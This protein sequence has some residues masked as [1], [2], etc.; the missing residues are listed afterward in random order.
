M[1]TGGLIEV[2]D[3][4]MENRQN[5]EEIV[6]RAGLPAAMRLI[7]G[8]TPRSPD[9]HDRFEAWWRGAAPNSRR[10]FASDM[11]SWQ[12]HC[13]A[14]GQSPV[15]TGPLELRDYIRALAGRQ[16][17]S[18]TVA[19]HLGNISMLH[20]I[21]GLG[22]A[23]ISDPIV[24]GEMK[25]LRRDQAAA[26][27]GLP[28]QATGLRLKGDVD[29]VVADQPLDLSVLSLLGT[30]DMGKTGH[31]RDALLLRLGADLGRRRSEYAALNVG[32]V[33]MAGDGSGVVIIRRSKTDQSGTGSSKYLSKAT[34]RVIRSWLG[35]RQIQAGAA[36]PPEA[37][38]LTAVDRFGRIGTRL[39]GSAIRELV[40]G[41]AKRGLKL[42]D[43]E[44]SDGD[45]AMRVEGL[46]GHSF[47]VGLAQDLTAAGEGTT[48]IC[49]AADWAS[50]AMPVRYGQA[51]AARSGAVA[52]LQ[53]RF[54]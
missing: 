35:L 22:P 32:D 6:A 44:I 2:L 24:R 19:R 53:R 50:P 9:C 47:R 38:L 52:R 40:I 11:R 1:L 51:L 39:S 48:A 20:Q 7:L 34:M 33:T 54:E 46:S 45:L 10:A 12:T 23:P 25:C 36:L 8:A 18:S 5:L 13:I 4:T 49:Q 27:R 17:R 21:M 30:L 42:L 37:P 31:V 28:R 29:D 26:G 16:L 43:P 14:H 15:P 3:A 41:I